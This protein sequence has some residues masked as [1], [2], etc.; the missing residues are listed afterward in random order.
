MYLGP[1]RAT[2]MPPAGGCDCHAHVFGPFDR[3]PLARARSYTPPPAPVEDLIARLDRSG[4]GRAVVVQPSAYG[5]DNRRTLDAVAAYPDRLRA[6]VV[7]DGTESDAALAG[8]HEAGAR[9]VRLNLISAGGPRGTT[10]AELLSRTAARIRPLG[11]H[12]QIYTDLD[13]I[14]ANAATLR[15]LGVDIV[16]DHMAK[17]DATQGAAHPQFPTL[18]RLID[19]GRF[20]VKLSGTYRVSP[21]PYGNAAVTALAQALIAANPERMVWG[22]DWPHLANHNRAAS[23]APPS[24]DY[25]AIDYGRLLSLVAEWTENEALT[26]QILSH[27]P[28]RLYD[29]PAPATT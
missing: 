3:Y 10:V 20:W 21:D 2:F 11:W 29:F 27:N 1:T 19:T 18:R 12:L 13:V 24:I 14:A 16:L 15:G 22:T 6:V 28:A 23:L 26:A 4:L 9:G 25:H 17:V 7:I 5:T 8:M